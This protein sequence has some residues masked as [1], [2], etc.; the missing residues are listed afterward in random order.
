LLRNPTAEVQAERIQEAVD[1][2]LSN[3]RI[4]H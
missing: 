1:A 3:V 2:V 4:A